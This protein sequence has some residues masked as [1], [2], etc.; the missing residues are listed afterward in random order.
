MEMKSF[1][2]ITFYCIVI[3]ENVLVNEHNYILMLNEYNSTLMLKNTTDEGKLIKKR[4]PMIQK[5]DATKV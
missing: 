5:E 1:I 2:Q 4:L 3:V